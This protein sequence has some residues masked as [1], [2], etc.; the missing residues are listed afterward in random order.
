M[1][2]RITILHTNDLHSHLERWPKIRRYLTSQ[3]AN[4]RRDNVSV[5]T[6][7]I[8]DAIDRYHPLT[9]A[10]MGQANVALMNEVHYDAVTIGN[11]EGLGIPHDALNQLYEQAN[12]PVIVSNIIDA[13]THQRPRWAL[14]YKIIT[15][16]AGTR[17]G[18]IGLTAPY[19][20]TYPLLDWQPV[21]IQTALQNV[22]RDLEGQTDFNILLS[23]LGILVDRRI[24]ETC[25]AIQVILGAHTH[26][27]LPHGERHGNAILAAAG[28][29]G[30][31]IGKVELVVENGQL[32]QLQAHTINTDELP[33][34]KNDQT[35]SRSYEVS[36]DEQLDKIVVGTSAVNYQRELDAPNR[37]ID[38]GLK[39]LEAQTHT[40]I[41]MLSTGLFLTDLPA[42]RITAK[43]IHTMLPH[44][45]H[46]M[47]TV[48][49]GADL[50]RL[51]LEVKKSRRFLLGEKVK[52]MGFRGN[53]WGEI[54]FD[55][56]TMDADQQVY[57]HNVPIE[58]QKQY[59]IG[60]LDH[61]LLLPYFPTLEIAGQNVL[62]Y[63]TVF[64]EDFATYL[65]KQL[66]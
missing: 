1:R 14:P 19:Q 60:S 7:D 21:E 17:I 43:T 62:S 20:L 40:D 34:Q 55:G 41:A 56:M 29:Y 48:L 27:H 46:A 66:R 9:E 28:R 6:F 65:K 3:Q 52:G 22:L 32:M 53:H 36:G 47:R 61:Y 26:H 49:S 63:D 16:A 44:A 15:T 33:A 24:A 45:I 23:H 10:T 5:L 35:E 11:N 51:M 58:M 38:L 57:V 54:V 64:R 25:S 42:G 39:A 50:R 59:A 18:I 8:G 4:L 30:E 37:L 12:F 13:R 2:E 31:H